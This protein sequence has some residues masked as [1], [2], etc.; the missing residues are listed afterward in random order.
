MGGRFCEC[1]A[2]RFS[3]STGGVWQLSGSV[4][5]PNLSGAIGLGQTTLMSFH[6]QYCRPSKAIL[7]LAASCPQFVAPRGS[8]IP[9]PPARTC[10]V[11]RYRKNSLLTFANSRKVLRN[12]KI[13]SYFV[14]R[15]K[16]NRR[17]QVFNGVVRAM[18]CSLELSLPQCVSIFLLRKTRR[19][20]KFLIFR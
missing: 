16:L 20:S 10:F 7:A 6:R 1:P 8:T 4:P 19:S 2:M 17:L 13:D 15:I 9:C 14:T 5:A 11:S 3:C 12:R 18:E